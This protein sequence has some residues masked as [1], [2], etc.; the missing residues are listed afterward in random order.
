MPTGP[1]FEACRHSEEECLNCILT[2]MNTAHRQTMDLAL[3]ASG[4]KDVHPGELDAAMSAAELAHRLFT[5][6]LQRAGAH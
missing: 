2:Q 6:L 5:Q 1:C 4:K 3:S